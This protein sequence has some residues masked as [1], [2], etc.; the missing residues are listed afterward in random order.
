[1]QVRLGKCMPP[2]LT[3]QI[4]VLS[5][6]VLVINDKGCVELVTDPVYDPGDETRAPRVGYTIKYKD[7][8]GGASRIVY[9][10]PTLLQ[11]TFSQVVDAFRESLYQALRV[12]WER[13]QS[14]HDSMRETAIDQDPQ[15]D[16]TITSG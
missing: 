14:L 6:A 3:G 1:M 5:A 11:G 9:P 15:P 10:P 2:L 13:E 12:V 7:V 16:A 4:R 8:L